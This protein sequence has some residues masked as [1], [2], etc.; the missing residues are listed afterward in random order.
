[1]E[2]AKMSR[3]AEPAPGPAV[4]VVLL[5]GLVGIIVVGENLEMAGAL[6]V[7]PL[8]IAVSYAI[9]VSTMRLAYELKD[10]TTPGGTLVGG[11]HGKCAAQP[12]VA[13]G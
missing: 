8:L 6:V 9:A 11:Q 5:A 4:C 10:G 12:G 1:M 13:D 7:G 3:P 2:L